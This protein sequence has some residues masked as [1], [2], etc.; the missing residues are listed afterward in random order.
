MRSATFIAAASFGVAILSIGAAAAADISLHVDDNCQ[1]PAL[2]TS[3]SDHDVNYPVSS[4]KVSSGAWEICRDTNFGNC[5]PVSKTG[6]T[7]LEDISFWG[8]V[9][10]VRLSDDVQKPEATVYRDVGFSG[11]AVY[12]STAKP[13]TDWPDLPIRSIRAS[14]EWE[15]CTKKNFKGVCKKVSSD[16][17][18][19]ASI[20]M[21]GMVKSLRPIRAAA[22]P[23]P[24]GEAAF[25]VHRSCG[26]PA[27]ATTIAVANMNYPVRS[28]LVRAG[29]WE[30][31]T[32]ENFGGVCKRAAQGCTNMIEAGLWGQVRSVRPVG[33]VPEKQPR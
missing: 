5:A 10:S 21:A 25:H 23:A 14:G 20:G 30:F 8:Q 4:V 9:R 1:G 17:Q 11:P 24:V 18:N 3:I 13:D 26:G 15:L 6:C 29:E 12:T 19:L 27:Y 22:T 33:A 28:V 32:G 2:S 16:T 31:C 7:N